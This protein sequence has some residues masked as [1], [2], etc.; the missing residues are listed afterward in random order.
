MRAPK[1]PNGPAFAAVLLAAAA[2]APSHALTPVPPTGLDHIL[3]GVPNL[4]QAIAMVERRTGV[5]PVPG[6][7]HP[8]AGT[9]NALISLGNDSYLELIGVD[10]AQKPGGFGEFV[11]GLRRMTPLG[12]AIRTSDIGGLHKAL[13]ERGV[14]VQPISSGSR[15]RPDGRKLEWR[16]FEIGPEED[17]SP[18]FIE[19]GRGSP[20]PSAG[21]T[22]GCRIERTVIGSKLKPNV[23]RALAI[24]GDNG[25]RQASGPPG[26]RFALKCPRGA[27]RL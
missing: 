20:H 19:W 1:R 11:A 17:I 9:R 5:R 22:T 4:E 6:G 18:F 2:A 25:V 27:M 16:T 10:P 12:W 15:L 3:V 23:R 8:G 7:S 14:R 21:T 26:L 13:S 24:V